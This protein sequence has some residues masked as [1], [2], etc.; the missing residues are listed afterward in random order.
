MRVRILRNLVEASA[1]Q[2][3]VTDMPKILDDVDQL[4]RHGDVRSATTTFNRAAAADEER[5]ASFLDEHPPLQGALFALEDHPLLRGNLGAFELDAATFAQRAATFAELMSRPDL[6]TDL[7]GALLAVG[8]YQRQPPDSKRTLLG[9]DSPKHERA[10]R[11]LLTG[12]GREGLADTRRVLCECLDLVIAAEGELD[13]ALR[14]I[15]LDCLNRCDAEQRFDWRYYMVKYPSMR[16]QGS[17]TY[18][19]ERDDDTGQRN[20]GYSLCMLKPGKQQLN[21]RYRDPYLSAIVHEL[22]DVDMVEDPWFTGWEGNP[23]WLR[24]SATGAG[25]RY[26]KSGFELSPPAAAEHVAAFVAVCADLGV[27]SGDGSW[28]LAVPQVTSDGRMVDT[29]DRIQVGAAVV[30]RLADAGL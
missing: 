9:T 12:A 27:D 13:D 8:E 11:E 22:G 18:I 1:D 28:R 7:L 21:S 29:A 19:G 26:T 10:W 14:K 2:L 17:S 16:A 24:L 3:R 25:L 30:R 4:V 15:S 5:K 6:W 23:R 20:M